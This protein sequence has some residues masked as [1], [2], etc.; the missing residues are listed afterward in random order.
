[1]ELYNPDQLNV[2]AEHFI[3]GEW[4]D[5][6]DSKIEVVRPSDLQIQGQLCNASQSSVD[7][8]VEAASAA[9]HSGSWSGKAP[10]ERAALL[11]R[12]AELID[13]HAVEIAQLE[14]AVS[15]RV[16]DETVARDVRVVANCLRF[17]GEYADKQNGQV[18]ATADDTLSLTI[19][20][21]WGVVAG[22]VPWNFPLILA[23]WKFAPAL[24]AGNCVVLKPSELTPYAV[25]RVAELS[26][27]AGIPRGVFNI[28]QGTGAN[29][30]AALV[31]HP[32]V[33]YITFKNGLLH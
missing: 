2:R 32:L 22:I 25:A 24:A 17:F 16:Y 31:K 1:M 6:N 4:T 19:S 10:R 23:A 30:G 14:S 28:I 29:A 12:W 21:P 27:E 33:Q 18:T 5:N 7:Q 3:N 8:A 26:V 20:E 13:A 15:C 11:R 9:F